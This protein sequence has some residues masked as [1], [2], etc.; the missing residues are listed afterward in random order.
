MS[1]WDYAKARLFGPLGIS[2]SDWRQDPQ[3]FSTG[4]LGL[5]L[6]P[7]D[8][9]KI[10]YLYLRNG[11]WEDKRVIPAA[12]VEAVNHATVNM[13]SPSDSDLR[14]SNLF[15]ALPNKQVYNHGFS[16]AGHRRSNDREGFLSVQ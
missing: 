10:G 16:G 14:Y 2:A 5:A 6:P 1:A 9:A 11:M 4:G 8:M 7:R 12:W 13:N 3:G 15:W